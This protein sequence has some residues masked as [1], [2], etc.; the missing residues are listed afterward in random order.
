MGDIFALLRSFQ[1]DPAIFTQ[2]ADVAAR[3]EG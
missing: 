2:P 3:W 1:Q